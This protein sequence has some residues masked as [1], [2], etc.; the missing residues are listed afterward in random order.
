VSIGEGSQHASAVARPGEI[1]MAVSIST[2]TGT[3][4][5]VRKAQDDQ[6]KVID[7]IS[8]KEKKNTGDEKINL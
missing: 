8:R 6:G 1:A 3:T 4:P 7:M 2:G 5:Q